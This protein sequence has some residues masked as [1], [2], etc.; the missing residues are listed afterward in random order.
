MNK[1]V[2]KGLKITGIVVVVL[3]A[4]YLCLCIIFYIATK[5]ASDT[6]KETNKIAAKT[7]TTIP[8]ILS[9]FFTYLF[10]L[11]TIP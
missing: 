6:V 3:A 5:L 8:V 10:I 2:K 1:Y 7:T 9:P 11:F 4:I